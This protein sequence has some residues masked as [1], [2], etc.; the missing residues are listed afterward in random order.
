M[1][2]NLYSL[3][4]PLNSHTECWAFFFFWNMEI[5]LSGHFACF[6]TLHGFNSVKTARLTF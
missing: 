1:Q 4:F 3:P 2:V 5:D 6:R